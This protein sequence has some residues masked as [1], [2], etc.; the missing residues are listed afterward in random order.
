MVE[1]LGGWF[2]L[3]LLESNMQVYLSIKNQLVS[4]KG[5]NYVS[6]LVQVAVIEVSTVTHLYF[7]T[8]TKNL[9]E[10]ATINSSFQL[11]KFVH[12]F[13]NWM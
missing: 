11:D 7:Q 8:F 13:K 6:C 3:Q 9:K 10:I 4:R 12:N 2:K 1:L 5:C